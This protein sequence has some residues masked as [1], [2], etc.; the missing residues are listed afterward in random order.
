MPCIVHKNMNGTKAGARCVKSL[1]EFFRFADI[2]LGVMEMRTVSKLCGR[3]RAAAKHSYVSAVRNQSTRYRRTNTAG[4]SSN[5]C[6]L[7][8]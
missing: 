3:V 6:V 2:R 4:A 7:A 1:M 5:Y 8:G